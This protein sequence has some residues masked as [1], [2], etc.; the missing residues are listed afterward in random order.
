MAAVEKKVVIMHLKNILTVLFVLITVSC[1]ISAVSAAGISYP[2]PGISIDVSE[3]LEY[4]AIVT[5]DDGQTPPVVTYMSSDPSVAD[6]D[7]SGIITGYSPG[8]AMISA[9]FVLNDT[10]YQ[11]S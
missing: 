11:A 2:D 10:T 3:S 5:L 1:M 4:P 6:V 8:S 9:E 7:P